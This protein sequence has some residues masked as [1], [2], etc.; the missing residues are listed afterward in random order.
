MISL[1]AMFIGA[2]P[3][4]VY[5]AW[6]S[7]SEHTAMTGGKAT[8]SNKVG[9]KFTAWDGYISGKHLELIPNKKIV[10][11]WRTSEFSNSDPDSKLTISLQTVSKGTK[12]TLQ[13]KGTP[14]SQ[15]A[16]YSAG[17]V[18]HYFQP[19][20]AYFSNQAQA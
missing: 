6:L 17:W 5:S 7:G 18:E 15:E 20:Q 12:L 3:A 2:T 19:M 8:G 10:Q 13:H 1:T 11:S 9:A 16:S 4:Q 14:K